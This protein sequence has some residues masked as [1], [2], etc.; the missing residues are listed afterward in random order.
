MSENIQKIYYK[1]EFY[2]NYV[3]FPIGTANLDDFEIGK[4]LYHPNI[5]IRDFSFI[6][7]SRIKEYNDSY[8]TKPLI[9]I[10]NKNDW[11]VFT[12]IQRHYF[13]NERHWYD[14][15]LFLKTYFKD[16]HQMM[17]IHGRIKKFP[18]NTQEEMINKFNVISNILNE[19]N[20]IE[21]KVLVRKNNNFM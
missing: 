18:C 12:K 20:K 9:A 19:K 15:G 14:G 7:I 3:D 4:I 21:N 8:E 16:R 2:N 1:L 6:L 5:K 11:K 10:Y 13:N 17:D